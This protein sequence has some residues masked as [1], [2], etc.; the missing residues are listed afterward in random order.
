[1]SDHNE[2]TWRAPHPTQGEHPLDIFE[3]RI[4]QA[5][6]LASVLGD[7]VLHGLNQTVQN[8]VLWLLSDTITEARIAHD[9]MQAAAP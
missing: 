5:E 9:A 7:G 8:S 1:M 2:V 4:T 3:R 6:A